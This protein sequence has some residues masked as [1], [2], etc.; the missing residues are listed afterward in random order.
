MIIESINV[1]QVDPRARPAALEGS[2]RAVRKLQRKLGDFY[3]WVV[4]CH[5]DEF[6]ALRVET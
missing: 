1:S 5:P 2:T 4:L 6:E 3:F